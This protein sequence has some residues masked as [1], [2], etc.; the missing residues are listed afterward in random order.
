L[1]QPTSPSSPPPDDRDL[2]TLTPGHRRWRIN[3]FI[4][5]WLSYAGY[6]FCRKNWNIVKRPLRD[7]LEVNDA[8]IAMLGTAFLVA[9]MLGQFLTAWLGRFV[10]CRRLLLFGMGASVLL[11]VG[12]GALANMGPAAWWP[13]FALS[14]ANGIAQGTGWGANIGLLAHWYRR[15]ERGTILA[16]WATCYMLGSVLAK[17]FTAY[18]YGW[19]GLEGA[20]FGPALI[21]GVIWL[22]FFLA[23]RDRPED[24]GLAPIVHESLAVE[25]TAREGAGHRRSLHSLGWTRD[26]KRTVLTMGIAYFC[27]KFVR[28]ALDSWTPML[29]EENFHTDTEG[30][31]Y[32]S[33]IFDLLGFFGVVAAGW[34]TDRYFKGSRALV[35]FA[36]TVGMLAGVFFTWQLGL[37]SLTLFLVGIGVVGFMLAGP[38]SLL[39][40][41]G[42]VDVSSKRGAVV[43]AAMINGIGS[44]GSVIQELMIGWMKTTAAS[45]AAGMR[46]IMGLLAAVSVIGVLTTAMLL[47]WRRTGHSNL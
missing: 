42:S 39:S 24:Y 10:S 27:F 31:G 14:F 12:M 45:D 2:V 4:V 11:N 37:T 5:T 28:Y 32:R 38:D 15:R 47:Y 30:A 43:A 13:F 29:L 35:T 19:Q 26:V 46:T 25:Q 17:A 16:F 41:V 20:F 18:M 8:E 23:V 3:L 7:V 6:Y 1:T 33:A 44:L 36:M 22:I 21:F 40:G 9:Y 34:L